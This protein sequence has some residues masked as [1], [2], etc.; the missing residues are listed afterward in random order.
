MVGFMGFIIG[1]INMFFILY[2]TNNSRNSTK[3]YVIKGVMITGS[4]Y[5]PNCPHN[6]KKL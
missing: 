1:C 4:K 3:G 5:D 6:Y 2:S